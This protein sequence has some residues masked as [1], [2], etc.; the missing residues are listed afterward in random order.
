MENNQKRKTYEPV[1]LAEKSPTT[2]DNLPHAE[3]VDDND[4]EHQYPDDEWDR[5]KILR[6][7]VIVSAAF[8]LLFTAFQVRPRNLTPS[9]LDTYIVAGASFQLFNIF[10]TIDLQTQG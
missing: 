4:L 3:E 2:T 10:Y 8:F 5:K 1:P 6:N 9:V 7:L